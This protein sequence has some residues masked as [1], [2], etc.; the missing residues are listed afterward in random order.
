M[1]LIMINVKVKLKGELRFADSIRVA[2]LAL[3]NRANM[4]GE[5]RI[6]A[7]VGSSLEVCVWRFGVGWAAR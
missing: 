3:Q 1:H 5:S 6:I 4:R 7:F 2:M